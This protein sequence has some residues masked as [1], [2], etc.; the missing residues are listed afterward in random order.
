MSARCRSDRCG[1][2]FES[3]RRFAPT[4]AWCGLAN[5][6]ESLSL[7]SLASPEKRVRLITLHLWV[8]NFGQILNL[9]G[10]KRVPFDKLRACSADVRRFIGLQVLPQDRRAGVSRPCSREINHL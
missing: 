3:I 4:A 10:E 9:R 1:L 2:V 6:P 7:R 8:F 5:A